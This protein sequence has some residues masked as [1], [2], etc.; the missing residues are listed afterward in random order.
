MVHV[1]ADQALEQ[2]AD[3]LGSSGYATILTR[4][5]APVLR[6]VNRQAPAL[7]EDIQTRDGWF[8]GAAAGLI[9]RCEDIPAAAQA[10]V[11]AVSGQAR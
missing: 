3:E 7:T 6:V 8:R 2:L 5:P 4:R 1:T 11:R 9:A 10:V